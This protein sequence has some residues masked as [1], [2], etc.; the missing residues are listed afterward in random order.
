VLNDRHAA[1]VATRG[2]RGLVGWLME[3]IRAR[4]KQNRY[5]RQLELVETLTL[6]GKRHL[7]LVNCDGTRFLVAANGDAPM[8]IVSLTG[9]G[10]CS[11]RH[12][13]RTHR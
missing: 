6:S 5:R 7:M 4:T 2:D 1:S 13:E 3:T 10:S 12:V 11:D 8:T 9:A